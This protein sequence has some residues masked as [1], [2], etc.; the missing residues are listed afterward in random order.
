MGYLRA[1]VQESWNR[2]N[3]GASDA[4][5]SDALRRNASRRET[6]AG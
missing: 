2:A 6:H 5:A 3:A 4:S 1:G